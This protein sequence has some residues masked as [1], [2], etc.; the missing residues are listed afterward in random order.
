MRGINNFVIT[1]SRVEVTR[2]ACP[3]Y[4]DHVTACNIVEGLDDALTMYDKR[5]D[6]IVKMLWSRCNV[7]FRPLGLVLPVLKE[8]KNKCK[9]GKSI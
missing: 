2:S 3:I 6:M 1:M 4:I 7:D 5:S 9:N 8:K